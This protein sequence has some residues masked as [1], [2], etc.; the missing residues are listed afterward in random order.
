MYMETM[1]T[2][3]YAQRPD[4]FSR[5]DK[6]LIL[7]VIQ[8][9]EDGLPRK[10]AIRIYGLGPSII[11]AWM[12]TYDSTH[13]QQ[14]LKR[15]SYSNLQKRTIVSAVEQGRMSVREAQVAYKVKA[16][17]TIRDWVYFAATSPNKDVAFWFSKIYIR[18]G[19][20]KAETLLRKSADN[21]IYCHY[22]SYAYSGFLLLSCRYIVQ[23]RFGLG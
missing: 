8:E 2:E 5:Y 16:A 12:R 3:Q 10:E 19:P 4:R 23:C 18:K 13:Y 6:R 14:H 15:N 17:K 11:R 1:Q 20:A 7:K 21:N 9:V 22:P